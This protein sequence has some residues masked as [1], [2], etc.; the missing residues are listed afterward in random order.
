MKSLEVR[1]RREPGQERL[2]GR[3]A[4]TGP[5]SAGG[6]LVFEYDSAFLAD[7][8]WLSPFKLPPQAGLIE[9]RDQEF[10][11]IFGLFDDSLPDGWGL[12]LMDRFFRQ[13]GS[14]LAEISVLDRLAYLG[15]RTMGALTY[16]PPAEPSDPS[17]RILDLHRMALASRQVIEGGAGQVLPLLLRAGGSPGGARPKVLVG[18]RGDSILSGEDDLP[19]GYSHWIVKFAADADSAQAGPAE[20]AYSLMAKEAGLTMPATRLFETAAG[21]RFFG[22]ERFD[23]QGNRRYHVHTFG[24]L[25]HANFRIPSCDYRQLL[26]VTRILTRNH[27][28][29]LE[30]Y[31][32]MVFN[33]LTHNRDDHVKNFAFRMSDEGVWELAPAYDLVYSEGP[34]GEHTMTV[35]GEGRAPTRR[36]LL[37]LAAP[38][39]ISD[40]DAESA[41][42]QVA[43]ASARWRTYARRARVGTKSAQEIG[44]AIAK[45]LARLRQRRPG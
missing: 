10:G 15:S 27:Q 23:R 1:L 5:R 31:R 19:P 21:E 18:L 43:A 45:C 44:K 29:V 25:I 35:A 34:G 37:N 28:D 17:D 3:L 9:H 2:V 13:Q 24:N 32:R 30:C 8:L 16:H 42:D 41:L 39:G 22:V 14:A 36:H 26:E 11:P 38:A 12:L 40:A 20:F 7:P 4:E 33:V 6:Q